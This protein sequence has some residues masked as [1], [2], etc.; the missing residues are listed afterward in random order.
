MVHRHWKHFSQTRTKS[1]PERET[2][3]IDIEFSMTRVEL[4]FS[5]FFLLIF[6]VDMVTNT[7]N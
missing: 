2:D 1:Q 6:Y 4:N 3:S 5:C 7:V